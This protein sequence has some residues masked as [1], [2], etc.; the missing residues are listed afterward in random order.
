[1]KNK[2]VTSALTLMEKTINSTPPSGVHSHLQGTAQHHNP[3]ARTGPTH[4]TLSQCRASPAE[5]YGLFLVLQTPMLS[6]MLQ[7]PPSSLAFPLTRSCKL[8]F[9][10]AHFKIFYYEKR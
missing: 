1:M 8:D 4:A 6:H 10:S 2:G 3:S 7:Q 5:E 9:R